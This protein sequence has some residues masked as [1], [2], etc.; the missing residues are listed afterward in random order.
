MVRVE[1][2]S[3]V[4]GFSVRGGFCLRG[5]RVLFARHGLDWNAFRRD[6]ISPAALLA[7]GDP[8]AKALVDH[9]RML[10]ETTRG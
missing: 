10:E 5:A 6:G 2:L 1:H 8:M 3:S 7:T 4:P 9:A